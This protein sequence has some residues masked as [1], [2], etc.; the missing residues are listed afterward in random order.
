MAAM[1]SALAEIDPRSSQV[2]MP[3]ARRACPGDGVIRA[4]TLVLEDVRSRELLSDVRR[5]A[6]SEATVL[7]VGETGTGKE[8]VARHVH[9]LS[10]RAHRPFVAVNCGALTESLAN[11]E[12][13]G[14]DKGA[15]TGAIS[16]KMGWFEAAA[17][18]TLFLDEVGDLPLSLQVKLL[19]VLQEREVVRVGSLQARPIDVRLVAATNLDLVAEMSARRF[20][21]D[22]YFR[23]SVMVLPLPAL[24]E[25]LGDILP[26]AD[27][28]LRLH[29][30][31]DGPPPSLTPAAARRLMEHPWPGNVRELE[32]VVHRA[33]VT[34]H[35]GRVE[36]HDLKLHEPAQRRASP[37]S[38][39]SPG[40][41]LDHVL[42][43]IF[44]TGRPDPYHHIE[45]AVVMAAYRYCGQNQ[46]QAARLLGVTR[47]VLRTRLAKLGVIQGRGDRPLIRSS[48]PACKSPREGIRVLAPVR[49]LGA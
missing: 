44:K 18:G 48:T 6:P 7:I 2:P 45:S 49:E 20:R 34:C 5:V 41:V 46:V 21:E 28:F 32:N 39:S 38:P 27:H 13:F 47:N 42:E 23:L 16:S 33:V 17:G 31:S 24:R 36:V 35:D 14:H 25:R 4:K 12:L 43:D 15:F 11:S 29:A 40:E 22:L 37:P 30:S 1:T 9:E 26:L 19:R 10:P 3:S 8:L